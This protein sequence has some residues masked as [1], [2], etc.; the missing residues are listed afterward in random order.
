MHQSHRKQLGSVSSHI[1]EGRLFDVL[2][3]L[4]PTSMGLDKIPA[5]FVK[6]GAPFLAAPLSD[7][8][9]LSLAS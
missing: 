7:M 1:T 6:I 3:T 2:D 8:F 9:N 4:R 5:W